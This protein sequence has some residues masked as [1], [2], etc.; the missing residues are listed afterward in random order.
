MEVNELTAEGRKPFV[1]VAQ[2]LYPTFA[3]LVKDQAFFDRTIAY[4]AKK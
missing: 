3:G 1:D 4:V 2:N